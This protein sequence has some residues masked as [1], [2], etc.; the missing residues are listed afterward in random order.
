MVREIEYVVG[1]ALNVLRSMD[2]ESIHSVVTSPPYWGLRNYEAD[3]QIGME[4]T[5]DD[6]LNIMVETF[7]EIRRVLRKDGTLWLN[8]GDT[9]AC[10]K[11]RSPDDLKKGGL[12]W[13]NRSSFRRDKRPREDD[14][15]KGGPGLKPKDI[16][17]IPWEVALALRND[18]W[19]LRSDIIWFKPNPMPESVRD[20]PTRCHEYLFLLTKNKKYFYDHFAIKE[21]VTGNAH[22]RGNGVNPKAKAAA[23]GSKQNERFSR[24]VNGPVSSRNKRTVWKISA[25]HFPGAHFATFPEGLVEPCIL[26][27]TSQK[28]CPVCLTPWERIIERPEPPNEVFCGTRNPD[29]GHINGNRKDGKYRGYGRRYQAWVNKNP[30]FTAGWEPRCKCEENDGSGHAVVLDPF[31]GSGTTLAVAKRLGRS[32]IGIDLKEEYKDLA[33]K[34][35]EG[36]A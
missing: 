15:Q 34:R 23:E 26:A 13:G 28:N 30:P 10:G 32:A 19:Y 7:R 20:R 2:S 1:D 29:D 12:A 11:A 3:G 22:S 5:P 35:L 18:G 16:V 17:G 25:S 24:A 4:A 31:A 36:V 21:P 27:A 6:Y 9:Y 33:M 14:P 8:L